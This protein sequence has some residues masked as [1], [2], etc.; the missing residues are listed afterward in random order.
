MEQVVNSLKVEKSEKRLNPGNTLL[1][2]YSCRVKNI[3]MNVRELGQVILSRATKIIT[4][5]EMEE[6]VS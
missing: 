6:A 2:G 3:N 4:L 5:T 1:K